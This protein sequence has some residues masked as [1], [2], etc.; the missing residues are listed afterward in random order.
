MWAYFNDPM[1][2]GVNNYTADRN[3]WGIFHYLDWN[4]SNRLSFGFFDSIIWA[5]KDDNGNARGFDVTYINPIVFLRPVEA[6]NGS[7]DNALIGL[8]GKY[9][10]CDE[11]TAYGQ[12]ALDEFEGK[13]FFSNNGSYRNKYSWQLGFRGANLFNVKNLNYLVETNN[14]KPYTYSE[15]SVVQNFS[16]NSE[17]LAHPWGANFRELVGL[18]NYSYKKFDFS[19]ELD[20]GHYGLDI[21]GLNYGKDIFQL[22]TIPAKQFGNYTGQGLTTNM[23]YMEGKVAYL[24]NPKYNLRIELGAILRDEKNSQF[25]NKTTMLTVG[26]RSSFRSLYTDLASYKTHQ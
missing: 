10:I 11:V 7:P 18:L 1:A 13:N 22:Y 19:G 6:S 3:K 16:E 12:F 23:F 4:V 21:N 20:Y 25:N 17:P 14:A 8:T 26:L 5:A 24:L 2:P 15:R 9:K